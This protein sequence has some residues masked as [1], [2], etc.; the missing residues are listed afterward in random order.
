MMA[1]LTLTPSCAAVDS[2]ACVIWKPPSPTIA[3]TSAS[4]RAI[5][6]PIAAGSPKPIVPEAARG[7]ERARRLVVVVLRLPHLVLADVGDDDRLALGD[8]PDVVDDVRRVEVAVVGQRLDVAHRRV[9]LHRA[10]VLQPRRRGPAASTTSSRSFSVSRRSATMAAS[11]A[12]V[13]VDLG[14][15]DVDVDLLGVERVGLEVAGDAVVEAHAEGEQQVG[16]LD[17]VV[18]PRLA[19]HAHHA[20]VERVAGR[21][22]AEAEQRHRHRRVDQL[23]ELPHFLHRPALQDALPG[24]DDRLASRA[25]IRST[26]LA[27]SACADGRAS[28]GSR[29]S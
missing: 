20:D 5:L 15:V 18:D 10:D 8:A 1:T 21:E 16:L 9:A 6:A 11:A 23:G 28:D 25:L 3:H 26:A 7:D 19:V 13:L 22:A 29:A 12:H 17:R 4:G 2:S 24:E 27:S 14:R